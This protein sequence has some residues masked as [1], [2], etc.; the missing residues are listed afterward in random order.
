MFDQQPHQSLGVEDELVSVGLLV[1][2]NTRTHA[3]AHA[4]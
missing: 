3:R 1:P 2:A 4:R